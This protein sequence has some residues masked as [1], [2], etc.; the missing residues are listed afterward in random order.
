LLIEVSGN[1]VYE[2]GE[3]V[4][5]DDQEIYNRRLAK[6]LSDLKIRDLSILNVQGVVD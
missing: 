4:D 5:E 2:Q 3:D 6:P 1:I